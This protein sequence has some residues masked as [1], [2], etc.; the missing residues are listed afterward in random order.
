MIEI[1]YRDLLT[2]IS[3]VASALVIWYIQRSQIR[4]D[5]ERDNQLLQESERRRTH[6]LAL[7]KES[8]ERA[9][10]RK[11]ET[12]LTMRMIKAVG[13][14]A[15]AN[16]V[17]IKEGKVNGVME[18]AMTYYKATSDDLS[19]FLQEQAAEHYSRG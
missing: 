12:L 17:A 7:A 9:E 19:Y 3:P 1:N 6:E 16:A 11:Q 14:L 15:Y 2:F 18:E 8:S 10:A 5:K 4:R 13:K